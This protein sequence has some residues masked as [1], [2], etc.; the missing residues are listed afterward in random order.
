MHISHSVGSRWMR[1]RPMWQRRINSDGSHIKWQPS[2][3]M[4][5]IMH[6]NLLCSSACCHIMLP[7]PPP[8]APCSPSWTFCH[9][10]RLCSACN[11]HNNINGNTVHGQKR[12]EKK[13]IKNE[14]K[15]VKQKH[16]LHEV[17]LLYLNNSISSGIRTNSGEWKQIIWMK[18]VN[19]IYKLDVRYA[20]K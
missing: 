11:H 3:A 10:L 15:H 5:E 13:K 7:S 12:R 1:I 18:N 19:I 2:H 17:D 9:C 4:W 6:K 16:V 14:I 8:P 20:I